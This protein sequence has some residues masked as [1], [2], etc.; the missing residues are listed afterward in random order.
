MDFLWRQKLAAAAMTSDWQVHELLPQEPSEI[1]LGSLNVIVHVFSSLRWCRS[2]R[3][4]CGGTPWWSS[5]LQDSMLPL[6]GLGFIPGK[7]PIC[8]MLRPK[9]K[10][11]HLW[12]RCDLKMCL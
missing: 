6:Q 3:I 8:C 11:N 4:S 7:D 2:L 5:G 10:E 9:S 12:S 1:N